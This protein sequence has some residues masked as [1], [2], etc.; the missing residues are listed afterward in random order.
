MKTKLIICFSLMGLMLSSC[1]FKV[2]PVSTLEDK[3]NAEMQ[4]PEELVAKSHIHIFLNESEVPCEYST[5]SFVRYTPFTMPIFAPERKQ[6]L[7]KFYKKAVL[8]A[9]EL[10]GNAIIIDC[11]GNFRVINAP[12][13]KEDPDAPAVVV[14]N[15]GKVNILTSAVLDKFE[16][17]TI[18]S[19]SKKEKNKCVKTLED[20]IKKGIDKCASLDEVAYITRKIDAW[21]NYLLSEGI[22]PARVDKALKGYR[23]DLNDVEK[24][25][26]KK[27]DRENKKK[28]K[29]I[30]KETKKAER[31]EKVGET[32]DKL[33]DKLRKNK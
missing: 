12:D 25:I 18:L 27:I 29:E 33:K 8:K 31:K 9:N 13:L 21:G 26:L 24:K 3:Y 1:A 28:E 23:N 22:K 5:I 14:D 4:T 20:E 6:L 19:L 11:M 10:G 16:D 30:E 15:K 7:K 32:I 2:F 17:G